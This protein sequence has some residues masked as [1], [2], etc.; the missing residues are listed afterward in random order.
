M[1]RIILPQAIRVIIPPTGNETISMLKTRLAIVIT[2]TELLYAVS[3]S[4][5]ELRTIPLLMRLATRHR[6]H[7]DLGA[8][9]HQFYIERHTRPGLARQ[10]RPRRG[11]GSIATC[12]PSTRPRRPRAARSREDVRIHPAGATRRSAALGARSWCLRRPAQEIRRLQLLRGIDLQVARQEVMHH[13]PSGSGVDV[14]AL[15]QSPG[16]SM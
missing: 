11:S 5:G 7:R 3:S 14:A 4:L 13:R 16:R 15:H 12:S 2:I 1:R 8:H 9:G 10:L 6:I